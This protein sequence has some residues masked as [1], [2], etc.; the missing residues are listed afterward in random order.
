MKIIEQ[1]RMRMESTDVKPETTDAMVKST[2]MSSE[3]KDVKMEEIQDIP[4]KMEHMEA[5]M[6]QSKIKTETGEMEKE[7]GKFQATTPESHTAYHRPSISATLLPTL[8]RQY[9]TSQGNHSCHTPLSSMPE[10]LL[11]S[12]VTVTVLGLCVKLS[13]YVKRIQAADASLNVLWMEIESLSKLLAFTPC[14]LRGTRSVTKNSF[15][16][17]CL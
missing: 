5:K 1:C 17:H 8:C 4:D 15:I 6:Q 2:E 11:I 9:G 12:S 14:K 13:D 3:E 7:I 10:P 16:H